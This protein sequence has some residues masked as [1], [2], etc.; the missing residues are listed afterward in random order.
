[1]RRPTNAKEASSKSSSTS[2]NYRTSDEFEEHFQMDNLWQTAIYES[3]EDVN[4]TTELDHRAS[5]SIQALQILEEQESITKDSELV[6]TAKA[7]VPV[8]IEIGVV[9]AVT[10]AHSP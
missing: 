6:E 7:F 2:L 4:M 5:S 8:A 1:M 10:S 3:R 9:A